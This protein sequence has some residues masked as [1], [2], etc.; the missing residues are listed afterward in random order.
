MFKLII[1]AA[2][3]T[4]ITPFISFSQARTLQVINKPKVY[5]RLVKQDSMQL[6]LPLNRIEELVVDLQYATSKN[7]TRQ[8]LYT[9]AAVTYLRKPVAEALHKAQRELAV[10]GLGFKV[11][12]AYRPYAVTKKMWELIQDER[13]VANP[14]KGSGHNRGIAV[15]LTLIELN[16]GKELDMGTG[17]DHFSD[18]AH[19]G[20]SGL[21]PEQ[22]QNRSLLKTT[23]ER[24]GFKTLSTEWWHYSWMDA[25]KFQVL[26]LSFRQLARIGN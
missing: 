23:M 20:F 1:F 17:F 11:W 7:F 21:S 25:S 26:D 12:D 2:L 6:L 5:K 19:H 22:Q 8:Q 15:D 3:I 10:S 4:T 24:Y 16:T 9:H 18:T 13:Y 14:A